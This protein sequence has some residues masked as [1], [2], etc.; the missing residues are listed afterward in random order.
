MIW[1]DKNETILPLK[2]ELQILLHEYVTALTDDNRFNK[3]VPYADQNY[4]SK[5]IG[6]LTKQI[7]GKKYTPTIISNTFIR[8][9]LSNGNYVWEISKLTLESVST[10]EKHILIQKT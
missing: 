8:K 5:Y 3:V 1:Q 10:I 4:L 7:I 6:N 2:A 9:A